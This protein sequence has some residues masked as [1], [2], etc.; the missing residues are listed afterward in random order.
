MQAKYPEAYRDHQAVVARLTAANDNR[1]P[2]APDWEQSRASRPDGFAGISRSWHPL[3]SALMNDLATIIKAGGQVK[4]LP[5]ELAD[6]PPASVKR[7]VPSNRFSVTAQGYPPVGD[8]IVPDPDAAFGFAA[9]TYLPE[10]QPRQKLPFTFGFR[11]APSA[12]SV[13]RAVPLEEIQPG[14]YRLYKLG[15]VTMAPDAE[16]WMPDWSCSTLLNI[17]QRL[18]EPGADNCWEVY[19]SLKFDGPT[20]GGDAENDLAWCDQV[21]LVRKSTD[22]FNK[23]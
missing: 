6:L 17:G 21:I 18:H 7:F 23:P 1:P 8:R 15:A 16:I 11:P 19:V 14:V 13:T 12:P 9:T 4:P 20:Y 22:Q 3:G 5:P 10:Q 2:P